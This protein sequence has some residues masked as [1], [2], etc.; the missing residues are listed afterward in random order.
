M[1]EFHALL[2]CADKMWIFHADLAGVP[3]QTTTLTD[4]GYPG[5]AHGWYDAQCKGAANDYCRYVGDY[6]NPT[7]S[8]ALAGSEDQYNFWLKKKE[9]DMPPKDATC[10]TGMSTC[11]SLI[12]II[13]EKECT[14][15]RA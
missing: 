13:D 8:C 3:R 9:E 10:S 1:C 6:G 7:W 2:M 15:F 12:Y 11:C 5:M 14:N 4:F